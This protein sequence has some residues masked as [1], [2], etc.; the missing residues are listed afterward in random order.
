MTK[1]NIKY[2]IAGNWKMNKNTA[3]AIAL[4]EQIVLEYNDETTVNVV[5]CPPFTALSSVSKLL[6]NSNVSLGAQ[7]M[8]YEARGAFT[9][10]ISAE[11]LRDFFVS[12]VILGHSERRQYFAETDDFINKKVKAALESN[13]RP[14]LCV[15][16][17]GEER[18]NNQT[19]NVIHQQLEGG[20]AWISEKQMDRLMI[21][22]EPVWAIGTGVTAT[23]EMAQEV[24]AAIRQKI[25]DLYS[26]S[27]AKK[28]P[29]LYGGSMKASNA[30]ALLEQP[31][32][33]GGLIGG[34]ALDA[35]SFI[36]LVECAKNAEKR[37]T[38]SSVDAAL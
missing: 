30:P 14:I 28:V 5:L 26:P 17:T 7:N 24:H 13:M 11:M 9:G 37:C 33:N 29:I 19:L 4:A 25:A 1:S 34:A 3:E 12:Y 35:R 31:D 36:E 32:I 22:Y 20:L 8:H 15:G 16:E 27:I 10:E 18:D 21:A 38:N 6:E 2:T 23:P